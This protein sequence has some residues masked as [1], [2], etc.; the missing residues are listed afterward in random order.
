MRFRRKCHEMSGITCKQGYH[1]TKVKTASLDQGPSLG[2][3]FFFVFFLFIQ[4][5]CLPL[6]QQDKF[7]SIAMYPYPVIKVAFIK[8]SVFAGFLSVCL[9]EDMMCI[10]GMNKHTD[11]FSESDSKNKQHVLSY[12]DSNHYNMFL[13]LWQFIL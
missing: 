13:I 1:C 2:S 6:L 7:T 8:Q 10:Y 3:F 5:H 9:K 11:S 12:S 4:L